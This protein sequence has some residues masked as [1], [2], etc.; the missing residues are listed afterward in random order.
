MDRLEQGLLGNLEQATR[1]FGYE[2]AVA[3]VGASKYL[4]W[5]P[6]GGERESGARYLQSK[7]NGCTICSGKSAIV[8][9]GVCR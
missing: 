4:R 7:L 5:S 2:R 9:T 1:I 6:A 8:P 3:L